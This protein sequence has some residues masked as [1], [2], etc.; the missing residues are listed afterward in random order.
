MQ[1]SDDISVNDELYIT[2]LT[3]QILSNISQ[4]HTDLFWLDFRSSETLTDHSQYLK[5]T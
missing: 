4:Q 1:C 2:E 3:Q 5:E